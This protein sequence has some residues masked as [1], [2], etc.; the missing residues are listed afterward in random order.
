MGTNGLATTIGSLVA[1][2]VGT[3][4]GLG[5]DLLSGILDWSKNQNQQA[6][7]DQI[8]TAQVAVKKHEITNNIGYLDQ[9]L[10]ADGKDGYLTEFE[11]LGRDTA[12][13]QGK[14][15]FRQA[16]NSVGQA[17]VLAAARGQAGG[18][19][20]GGLFSAQAEG[21]LATQFGA[22]GQLD[23]RAGLFGR[24]YADMLQEQASYRTQ[25]SDSRDILK[26][27]L[28]IYDSIV[29]TSTT[30]D[31]PAPLPSPG[32]VG[33]RANDGSIGE[34]TNDTGVTPGTT[35][36]PEYTEPTGTGPIDPNAIAQHDANTLETIKE[37]EDASTVDKQGYNATNDTGIAATEQRGAQAYLE[38]KREWESLGYGSLAEM[39]A[40]EAAKAESA[41]A[42]SRAAADALARDVDARKVAD[43][44]ALEEEKR[45]TA[46][47][48]K[49]RVDE[50]AAAAARIAADAENK[51][52]SE[53]AAATEAADAAKA[54]QELAAANKAAADDAFA[55][56]LE[57]MDAKERLAAIRE[58][59]A[60][61]AAFA[62]AGVSA[63]DRGDY[64]PNEA[65]GGRQGVQIGGLSIQGNREL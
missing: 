28:G 24:Q 23:T 7:N 41:A 12:L 31:E 14:Q 56:S 4:V 43:I 36:T 58:R 18:N 38:Q 6:I 62:D 1:P 19:S 48:T 40:G 54:E 17:N 42:A 21:D 53:A 2:G 44:A 33:D 25:L 57:Q 10:G 45:A 59:N 32:P 22:A 26:E 37:G 16:E 60:T 52:V 5:I 65:A 30:T 61:F 27:T 46:A 13:F 49:A 35:G 20:S 15:A 50:A 64:T 51:R 47:A 29:R 8:S 39:R 11:G 9:A 3:V 63:A 55:L 34:G